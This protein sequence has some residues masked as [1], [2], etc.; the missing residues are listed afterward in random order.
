MG[1]REVVAS[2]KTRIVADTLIEACATE[3]YDLIALPGGIPGAEYLRDSET[4]I[5]LVQDQANAGRLYAAICASPAVALLPHGFLAGKRATCFPSYLERLA[6]AK[7]V[8]A[9]EE[10]VVI[11]GNL[12]TSRGP[13]TA[14]EFALT[15]VER[16]FD[17][18]EK[19]ATLRQ[20]MLVA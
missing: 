5:S 13:G 16:L 18:V 11:D 12:I 7:D 4:L 2:R 3:T 10:R 1:R 6:D 15:L 20:R 19:A 9:L 17:D 14:I 8:H